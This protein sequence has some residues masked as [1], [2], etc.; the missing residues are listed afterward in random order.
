MDHASLVSVVGI[1]LLGPGFDGW[2]SGR[3]ILAGEAS[4]KAGPMPTPQ[5]TAL[6]SAERRRCPQAVRIALAVA[7]EA[8]AQSGFAPNEVATVF[9]ASDSDGRLTHAAC[10]ALAANPP[11]SSPTR[12]QN[13]VHNAAAGYWGI[14][15]RSHRPSTSISAFD[16]TFSAALLEATTQACVES[17]PVLAVACDL[18]LPPP[19][20]VLRP[21]QMG[22]A[23]AMLIC[24]GELPGSMATLDI[25]IGNAE[26]HHDFDDV[27]PQPMRH[28]PSARA[29][30][31]LAAIAA[32][33]AGGVAIDYL[34]GAVLHVNVR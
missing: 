26:A 24:P 7:H 34:D 1:G 6:P 19:L 25:S 23:V 21:M 8:L 2:R 29:L 14:A 27:V 30:P 15:T 17:T 33:R 4:W 9:G 10:E 12:F 16:W 32:G 22:L 11:V 5:P 31:L 3:A 13:S 18:P 28:T 20:S